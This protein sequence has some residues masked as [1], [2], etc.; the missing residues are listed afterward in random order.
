MQGIELGERHAVA[1]N[2][3]VNVDGPRTTRNYALWCCV[4][5]EVVA[6][7]ESVLRMMETDVV[8]FE[9]VADGDVTCGNISKTVAGNTRVAPFFL[10]SV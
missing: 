1:G 7:E 5:A 9:E 8:H 2:H 4:I 10:E 3:G 6:I